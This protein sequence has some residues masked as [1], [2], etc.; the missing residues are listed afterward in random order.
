[1]QGFEGSLIALAG[2]VVGVAQTCLIFWLESR[3]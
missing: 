2:Y 3:R 1:M